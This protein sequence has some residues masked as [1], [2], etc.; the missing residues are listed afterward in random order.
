MARLMSWVLALAVVTC[1]TAAIAAKADAKPKKSPD[2]RFSR[3]DKDGDKKLSLDEFVGK[4]TDAKKDNATKRFA[5]LDK[6]GDEYLSLEE[7]KAA[8]KKKK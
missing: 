1:A 8:G 4:K 2:E 6:D 5:K 7:Y 3:L